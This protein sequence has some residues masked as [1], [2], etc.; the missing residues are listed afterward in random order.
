MLKNIFKMIRYLIYIFLYL[1]ATYT[2]TR[3]ILLSVAKQDGKCHSADEIKLIHIIL[4]FIIVALP[5]IAY[6]CNK[7]QKKP[8]KK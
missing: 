2:V 1:G 6:I 8:I 4:A 7:I 5:I 3:I